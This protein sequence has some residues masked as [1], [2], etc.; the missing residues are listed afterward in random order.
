MESQVFF[1]LATGYIF[2]N[3]QI[4]FQTTYR[5]IGLLVV[6][7][8]DEATGRTERQF[9]KSTENGASVRTRLEDS[10]HKRYML[11]SFTGSWE[12]HVVM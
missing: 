4:R 11:I 12:Q 5:V 10:Q 7:R 3:V 2:V 6:Q 8:Q 9:L 1:Q